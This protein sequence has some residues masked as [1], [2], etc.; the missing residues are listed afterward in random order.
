M[1]TCSAHDS[2]YLLVRGRFLP[3]ADPPCD[4]DDCATAAAVD[5]F[6]V[7]LDASIASCKAAL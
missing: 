6:D 1:Q 7:L 3:G 4:D 5:E 2:V